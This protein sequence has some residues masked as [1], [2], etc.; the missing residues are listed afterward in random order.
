[1]VSRLD[2]GR[3]IDEVT[4]LVEAGEEALWPY[5]KHSSTSFICAS[6]WFSPDIAGL[7]RLHDSCHTTGSA[8]SDGN[9][10][11][12]ACIEVRH[13]NKTRPRLDPAA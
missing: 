3:Q 5:P 10:S 7:P 1:M 2:Y 6:S 4:T 12:A 9:G 8:G 13:G 11:V